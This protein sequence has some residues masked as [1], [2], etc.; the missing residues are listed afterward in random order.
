MGGWPKIIHTADLHLGMTFKN[1]G[2]R[3]KQHR[4]DCLDVFSNI[5][6]LCIKE[7]AAFTG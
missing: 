1:L 5:I 6:D 7:Q 4:R 2:D 3:S